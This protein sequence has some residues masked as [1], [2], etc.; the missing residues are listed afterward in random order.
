MPGGLMDMPYINEC[1]VDACSYN[2]GNACH[3]LA[4]TVGGPRTP[5]AKRISSPRSKAVVRP[6]PDRSGHAR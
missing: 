6:P 4:I 5:S 2:V 1:A 3:A